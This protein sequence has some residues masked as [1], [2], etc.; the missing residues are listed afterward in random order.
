MTNRQQVDGIQV[1]SPCSMEWRQ[2]QGDDRVRF[3]SACSLHVYNL[4]AMDVE[5]AAQLISEQSSGLCV[6][7]Y[8]RRDG[9]VLTRDCPV[10]R[11]ILIRRKRTGFWGVAASAGVLLSV[12]SP[13]HLAGTTRSPDHSKK[14][15]VPVRPGPS[16]ANRPRPR[17]GAALALTGR[18]EVEPRSYP[19]PLMP[20]LENH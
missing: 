5:E 19:E 18:V 12:G 20:A 6:R 13:R 10:G 2:M 17:M 8:R 1:A 7:L 16:H 4:S 14:I 9:T 15:Q 11:Q 3:C